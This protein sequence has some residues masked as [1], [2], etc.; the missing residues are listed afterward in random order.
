MATGTFD[1]VS[2]EIY[3]RP[4]RKE[5][6]SLVEDTFIPYSGDGIVYRHLG[7]KLPRKWV[8]QIYTADQ[9]TFLAL[10][11]K[12]NSS[13]TLTTTKDGTVTATLKRLDRSDEEWS[14]ETDGIAEFWEG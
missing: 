4:L 5:A 11:A 6:D 3:N 9:A 2:F 1:G 13:A 8:Y 7:G 12:R 14:G 10:E